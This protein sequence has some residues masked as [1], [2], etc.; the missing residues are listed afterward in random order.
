[1]RY[2]QGSHLPNPTITSVN[3][4]YGLKKRRKSFGYHSWSGR[5]VWHRTVYVTIDR[6]DRGDT[7]VHHDR[8]A[9][10]I[11]I[12]N[13]KKFWALT[14]SISSWSYIIASTMLTSEPL[15]A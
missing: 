1:M 7:N 10:D 9:L 12:Y 6:S 5:S 4:H 14:R 2:W 11:E 15:L 13:L 3:P 8:Y